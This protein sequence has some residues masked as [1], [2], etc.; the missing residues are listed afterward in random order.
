[1]GGVQVG[2]GEVGMSVCPNYLHPLL[3]N[4]NRRSCNDGSREL[5]PVFHNPHPK[6]PTPSFG[7]GSHFGVLCWSALLGRVEWEGENSMFG[8]ISSNQ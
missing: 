6:M 1:M 3:E 4:I 8:S 2:W 5:I 7:G